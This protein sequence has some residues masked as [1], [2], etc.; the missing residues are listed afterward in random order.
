MN[1]RPKV[2]HGDNSFRH[3][4]SC[5][6]SAAQKVSWTTLGCDRLATAAEILLLGGYE[7]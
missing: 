6:D 3:E 1:G 4:F 7:G 5:A 2:M